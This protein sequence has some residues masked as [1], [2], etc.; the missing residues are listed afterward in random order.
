MSPK[1]I[2]LAA[3]ALVLILLNAAIFSKED[4]LANGSVVYIELTPVDPRSLMQGDYMALRFAVADEVQGALTALSMK[5]D[6]TP[7]MFDASTAGGYVIAALDQRRVG[8]Y[9]RL[10]GGQILAANEVRMR[11][12]IKNSTVK[13]ATNA[14]FFQEGAGPFF[15]SARYGKFRVDSSGELLLEALCDAD[16]GLLEDR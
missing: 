4:H 13:F 12:R 5:S 6:A 1:K 14:Y 10:D 15:A 9:V 3:L 7:S 8:T 16:L 11:Y 2:A